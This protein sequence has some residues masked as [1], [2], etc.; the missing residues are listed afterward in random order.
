MA[1]SKLGVLVCLLLWA[2]RAHSLLQSGALGFP[3]AQT[4]A[5]S[6]DM[7]WGTLLEMHLQWLQGKISALSENLL[8]S[9]R[10]SSSHTQICVD[11]Q[12]TL[13]TS[14]RVTQKL[15]RSLEAPAG[16]Q[17]FYVSLLHTGYLLKQHTKQK[18]KHFLWVLWRVPKGWTLGMLS[19]FSCKPT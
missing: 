3:L 1:Q 14:T 16:Q 6:T 12:K 5:Y 9:N 10:I 4:A 19:L 8:N 18:K 17:N 15:T 2:S 11:V 7:Q 13:I